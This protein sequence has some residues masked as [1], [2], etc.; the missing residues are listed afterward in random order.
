LSDNSTFI[1]RPAT[2]SEA[3]VVGL[4]HVVGKARAASAAVQHDRADVLCAA[5]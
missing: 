4:E 2:L 1:G 3:T 5:R